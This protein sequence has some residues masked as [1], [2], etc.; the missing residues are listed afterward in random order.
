MRLVAPYIGCVCIE[1]QVVMSSALILQVNGLVFTCTFELNDKYCSN[2]Y[3]CKKGASKDD[4]Y[5][6]VKPKIWSCHTRHQLMGECQET[7]SHDV[8]S[9]WQGVFNTLPH[10]LCWFHTVFMESFC[11]IGFLFDMWWSTFSSIV[12]FFVWHVIVNFYFNCI[13]AFCSLI[14]HA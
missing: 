11:S 12:A 9:K 3:V 5:L 4:A 6:M 14:H 2:S 7:L 13:L 10:L 1:L 8:V